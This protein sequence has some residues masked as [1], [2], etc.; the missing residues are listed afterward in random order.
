MHAA[1]RASLTRFLFGEPVYAEHEGLQA[2]QHRFLISIA[3][4]AVVFNLALIALFSVTSSGSDFYPFVAACWSSAIVANL[5]LWLWLRAHPRQLKI[6]SLLTATLYWLNLY[7]PGTALPPDPLLPMWGV[8]MIIG[9]FM[10]VGRTWGWLAF[11]VCLV[12][13]HWLLARID[14]TPF[15]N[16]MATLW[17]VSIA[18]AVLG[19]IYVAR[20]DYFFSRMA[21]YNERLL[22]LSEHDSLTSALNA[23][24]FY[25]QCNTQMTLCRRQQLPY[26]V[27]FIDLDH[28]KR[29]NDNYGHAMGDQVLVQVAQL[30]RDCLRDND[31]L[32]RVGGEE[33][34][35]FLP[36]A[37][38]DGGHAV[39]ERIRRRIQDANMTFNGRQ[40]QVTASIGLMWANRAD[41]SFESIHDIQPLADKAMYEAKRAGR[42]Q[43]ALFGVE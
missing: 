15:P 32:G 28:F 36:G 14:L 41:Q 9:V 35:I 11:V 33:F 1:R 30:A 34:S 8:L 10:M 31:L 16:A 39:A 24:A 38:L 19:H 2:F 22:W 26:V 23:G 20:F 3:L 6:G 29:V 27:L 12:S 40:T 17:F 13:S 18:G 43:V 7:V 5:A 25:E 37:T 21:Y 4:S 42:N